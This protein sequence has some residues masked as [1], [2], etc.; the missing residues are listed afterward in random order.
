MR[1]PLFRHSLAALLALA[2]PLSLFAS[3]REDAEAVQDRRAAE[4]AAQL[5]L[6]RIPTRD[7]LLKGSDGKPDTESAKIGDWVA[8]AIGKKKDRADAEVAE[9]RKK[10]KVDEDARLAKERERQRRLARINNAEDLEPLL[11][12]RESKPIAVRVK[13]EFQ[14]PEIDCCRRA[15]QVCRQRK[16]LADDIVN[17]LSKLDRNNDGKLTADEYSD[18]LALVSGSARLFQQI[19]SNE[20]GFLSD[21]EIDAARLL[22][23]DGNEARV[24]GRQ[25][26]A[27]PNA[28][29]K[30]YDANGDGVLDGEER[31]ALEMAFVSAALKAE[32]EAEYY[33]RLG[34]ALTVSRD[35]IAARFA[36]MVITAGQ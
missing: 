29:I 9:M 23:R 5:A 15:E 21:A 14:A 4:L 34:D 11:K 20:D 32:K 16:A 30:P 8:E 12:E 26:A 24:N 19:D 31:K 3:D 22:P 36:D 2:A 28:R 17:V 10:V 6:P 13:L 18:A 1:L 35:I 7:A 33:R 27:A 25:A